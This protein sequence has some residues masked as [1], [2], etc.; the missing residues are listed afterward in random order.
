MIVINVAPLLLCVMISVCKNEWSY[1]L[2]FTTDIHGTVYRQDSKDKTDLGIVCQFVQEIRKLK[3]LD[4]FTNYS[5]HLFDIGDAVHGHCFS[6]AIKPTGSVVLELMQ[7]LPYECLAIGNHEL[8]EPATINYLSDIIN[9][10]HSIP[11]VTTNV[12][13]RNE[14]TEKQFGSKLYHKI[15]EDK[16]TQLFVLGFIYPHVVKASN[17]LTILDI[18]QIKKS[19]AINSLLDSIRDS[20]LFSSFPSAVVVLLHSICPSEF[21]SALLSYLRERLTHHVPLIVLGGHSHEAQLS[22]LGVPGDAKGNNFYPLNWRSSFPVVSIK[23]LIKK[24]ITLHSLSSTV[25]VN[26]LW[27]A[28]LEKKLR[29]NSIF[30]DGGKRLEVIS[31]V[32]VCIQTTEIK[33]NGTSCFSHQLKERQLSLVPTT[34]NAISEFL[35]QQRNIIKRKNIKKGKVFPLS[36]LL[37]K[38]EEEKSA[39]DIP[40]LSS[41]SSGS[42]ISSI[43]RSIQRST[44]SLGNSLLLLNSSYFRS[45]DFSETSQ[46]TWPVKGNHCL[47]SLSELHPFVDYESL[48]PPSII[49]NNTNLDMADKVNNFYHLKQTLLFPT[50]RYKQKIEH[51]MPELHSFILTE[52]WPTIVGNWIHHLVDESVLEMRNEPINLSSMDHSLTSIVSSSLSDVA[53]KKPSSSLNVPLVY[54]INLRIFRNPLPHPSICFSALTAAHLSTTDPYNEN[55][56]LITG[57]PL[58]LIR[59]L[60]IEAKGRWE[61]F[62]SDNSESHLNGEDFEGN[63]HLNAEKT[64]ECPS[65][66]HTLTR[67]NIKRKG[68][69]YHSF[70]PY[71]T[72]LRLGSRSQNLSF[73]VNWNYNYPP[74]TSFN[75][76]KYRIKK[77]SICKHDK[78]LGEK[79]FDISRQYITDLQNKWL[80]FSSHYQNQPLIHFPEDC[81]DLYVNVVTTKYNA[82]ILLE[83]SSITQTLIKGEII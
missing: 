51:P 82:N 16:K 63:D 27:P 58:S 70:S 74:S 59:R 24:P 26:Q 3:K 62:D 35:E 20:C 1:S 53:D 13:W 33:I 75:L 39:Y 81:Y 6:D 42:E 65:I 29:F 5:V 67:W 15:V 46:S 38:S 78:I 49:S 21:S 12:F 41:S 77:K 9:R 57:V 83:F 43:I 69:R 34:K 54:F 64:K 80:L 72:F 56:I 4:P 19:T 71:F 68:H 40:Q 66:S 10:D 61:W 14:G 30:L 11:Y 50:Y 47:F 7:M 55:L 25:D 36:C 76:A 32:D 23:S 45:P 60:S 22:P 44:N 48:H 17:N 52:V 79:Q 28:Y 37:K 31:M 18:E 73:H 2:I 8:L